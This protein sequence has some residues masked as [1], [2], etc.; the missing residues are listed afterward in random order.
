MG[1][2]CAQAGP[3]LAICLRRSGAIQCCYP[4]ATGSGRRILMLRVLF[5]NRFL[6]DYLEPRI[7][8]AEKMADAVSAEQLYHISMEE[9]AE[10][11]AAP[12]RAL[13]LE[14]EAKNKWRRP[15]LRDVHV[16]VSQDNEFRR[17]FRDWHHRPMRPGVRFVLAIPFDGDHKLFKMMPDPPE[18]VLPHGLIDPAANGGTL[19]IQTDVPKLAD[20]SEIRRH[21]QEREKEQLDLVWHLLRVQAAQIHEFNEKLHE[22]VKRALMRRQSELV[23]RR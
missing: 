13:P 14:L 22:A 11:L 1:W 5:R 12:L 8:I 3:S 9:L 7:S 2:G 17:Y 19:T 20:R 18:M 4:D 15:P 23:G 16:D 6:S 10:N 21:W